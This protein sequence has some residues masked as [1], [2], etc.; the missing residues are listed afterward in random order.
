MRLP[1]SVQEIAD[2]IGRE[3]ALYLIGQLPRCYV[4]RKGHKGW[5]VI[6]Y[7]PTLPRLSPDHQLS[8]IL[9]WNDAEKLARHFGGEILQ[10]ANC[11][12]IYRA[13]RDKVII[14]KMCAGA[15]ASDVAAMMEMTVRQIQNIAREITQEDRGEAAND[16]APILKRARAANG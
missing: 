1:A 7:V 9:G 10:P 12:E 13:Y 15:K 2:V 3:R 4:D 5:R 6:L 11:R 16:N 14:E 8:Q